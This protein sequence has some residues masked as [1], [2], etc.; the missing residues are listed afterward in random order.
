[1]RKSILIALALLVSLSACA[2][3]QL[4]APVVPLAKSPAWVTQGSCTISESGQSVFYGV[5]SAN[6]IANLALLKTTADNRARAELVKLFEVYSASLMKDYAAATMSGKA[7]Q[8]AEEQHVEQAIKTVASLSLRGVQ[9]VEHWQDPKTGE[10][11]A[12][13]KLDVQAFNNNLEQVKGLDAGVKASIKASAER[14]HTELRQETA[15]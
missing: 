5:G 1:M 6:G 10:Y 7:D 11:F 8:V 3:K 13:A 15:K 9:I 4:N 2:H 14:L 12:R